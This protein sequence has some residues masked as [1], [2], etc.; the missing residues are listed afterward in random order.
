LTR[1]ALLYIKVNTIGYENHVY[2]NNMDDAPK[3][4]II[5]V[6]FMASNVGGYLYLYR[7]Y[8]Y[9]NKRFAVNIWKI[10]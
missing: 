8:N 10:I 7:I 3:G 4:A 2:G 5:S 1:H 9:D 6:P